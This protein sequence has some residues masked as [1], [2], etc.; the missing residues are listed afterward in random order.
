MNSQFSC[1]NGW[2]LDCWM[3]GPAAARTCPKNSGL[4][5]ELVSSRRFS[6]CQAG[7]MLWKRAGVLPLVLSS[8]YQPKPNPSPFTVSAP[9]G[10][11]S[12]MATSECWVSRISSDGRSG[13]PE[14]ASQRHMT[15]SSTYRMRTAEP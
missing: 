2:Q 10:E 12:D 13:S 14:Y 1:R 15:T 11:L 7:S 8:G 6:S 4:A 9:S 3:G 5:I